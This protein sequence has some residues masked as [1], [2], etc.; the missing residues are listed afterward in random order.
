MNTFIAPDID[1]IV[2]S[3]EGITSLCPIDERIDTYSI[4]IEYE[5]DELCIEADSLL[6]YLQGFGEKV[7][8]AEYLTVEIRDKIIETIHPRSCTVITTQR[9]PNEMVIKSVAI[10]KG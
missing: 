10:L 7:I 1:R 9:N 3:I 6:F 2:L 5:P 4:E 8:F